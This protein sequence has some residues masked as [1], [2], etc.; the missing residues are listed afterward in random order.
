[1][2]EEEEL[3]SAVSGAGAQPFAESKITAARSIVSIRFVMCVNPFK[4]LYQIRFAGFFS[5][6]YL[7]NSGETRKLQ[8]AS[9]QW[10]P[11]PCKRHQK[12]PRGLVDLSA[13]EEHIKVAV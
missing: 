3:F 5:T 11:A 1:M 8:P 4:L 12:E 9:S 7:Y 13:L 6:L 2:T 10:L